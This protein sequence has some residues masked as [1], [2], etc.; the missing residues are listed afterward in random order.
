MKCI[1][2][3]F[4]KGSF[5]SCQVCCSC[6]LLHSSSFAVLSVMDVV[7]YYSP[8]MWDSPRKTGLVQVCGGLSWPQARF[9]LQ[10]HLAVRGKGIRM[11]SGFV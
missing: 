2:L 3:S 4:T 9:C 8:G 7:L 6:L 5:A 11:S 1:L 10:K